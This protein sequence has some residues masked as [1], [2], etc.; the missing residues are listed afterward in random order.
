MS[1]QSISNNVIESEDESEDEKKK[2]Y[3][4]EVYELGQKIG[5]GAH[6][7]V[8]K[9]CD[10]K[11]G[12]VLAVKTMRLDDEHIH[13]LKKNFL[14]IKDLNHPNIIK[15]KALYFDKKKRTCFLVMEYLPF[16]NLLEIRINTEQVLPLHLFR[17]SRKLHMIL[18]IPFLIST[19]SIFAIEISNLTTSF[20]IPSKKKSKL[21][22]SVSVRKCMIEEGKKTC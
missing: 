2:N 5:E 19:P 3:F 11:T 17:N 7:L 15:Y 13:F 14:A 8:R 21:L 20:T 16:P 1:E 18:Q 22:I 4:E 6:G 9:C 12:V 10:K